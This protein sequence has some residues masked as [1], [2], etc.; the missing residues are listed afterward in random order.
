MDIKDNE[1]IKAILFLHYTSDSQSSTS[2]D[3]ELVVS[4]LSYI[5]DVSTNEYINY[6]DLFNGMPSNSEDICQEFPFKEYA[7]FMYMMIQ[8]HVQDPL[9]NVFIKFFNKY[10]NHKDK[11]LP[12]TLQARRIFIKQLQLPNFG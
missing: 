10:F 9:A 6:D 4:D 1:D 11:L 3:D 7:E 12:S 5:T 8:F 2:S